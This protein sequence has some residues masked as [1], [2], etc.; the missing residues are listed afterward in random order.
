M[1]RDELVEDPFRRVG[2]GLPSFDAAD[3][4]VGAAPQRVAHEA[5]FRRC[6]QVHRA[7]RDLRPARD[8]AHPQSGVAALRGLPQRRGL[9]GRLGP[10]APAS[11]LALVVRPDIG[12]KMT[13]AKWRL[14]GRPLLA[15]RG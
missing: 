12:Y 13:V 15:L 5:L 10:R 1:E 4:R 11:A 9:D 8:L 14:L 3:D 7:G 2:A 6:M